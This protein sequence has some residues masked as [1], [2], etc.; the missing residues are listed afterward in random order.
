MNETGTNNADKKPARQVPRKV[1][2]DRLRNIALYHLERYATSAQN[3]RRV[4][5][6]RA[7]KA[8]MHHETDMAEAKSWVAEVVDALVRSGAVD[9]TRYAEGKAITMVRRGQSPTK[10]RAYL[11]AKGVSR[12][13]INAA[14]AAAETEFGDAEILAARAFA[15]RRHFGPFRRT[16]INDYIRKKELAA[17]GRAG[18]CYDVARKVIDAGDESELDS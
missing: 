15:L 14:I 12:E 8:A 13:T 3:L 10:V 7:F 16:E 4:L 5:E 2:K 9:D 1:T 18:F 11:A 6:R 17:L